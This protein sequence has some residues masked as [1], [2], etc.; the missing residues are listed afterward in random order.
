[1]RFSFSYHKGLLGKAAVAAP[2]CCLVCVPVMAKA[3][4]ITYD[5]GTTLNSDN[6]II[7]NVII[8]P[9]SNIVVNNPVSLNFNSQNIVALQINQNM[10]V[11]GPGASLT[12]TSSGAYGP[13]LLV[14][15][16]TGGSASTLLIDNGAQVSE[17]GYGY[18]QAGW[19]EGTSGTITVTGQG[20][21]LAAYGVVVGNG[22]TTACKKTGCNNTAHGVLNIFN[23]ASVTADQLLVGTYDAQ[24]TINLSNATLTVK[25]NLYTNIGGNG[26][27]NIND[28]GVLV[29]NGQF[30]LGYQS[31]TSHG[32]VNLNQGGVL[33]VNG[34]Q[35]IVDNETAQGGY[36][37]NLAGGTMQII[38]AN[39]TTGVNFNLVNGT[40]S[41]IDTNGY[42][43]T[44][45]GTLSGAG[46]LVK[47]GAGTLIL[48]GSDTY[49][50]GTTIEDGTVQYGTNSNPMNYEGSVSGPL[51]ADLTPDTSLAALQVYGT[52]SLGNALI[53]SLSPPSA[54]LPYVLGAD[55]KVLTATGGVSGGG[56]DQFSSISFSGGY[57]PYL[58]GLPV[59][60]TNDVSVQVLESGNGIDTGRFYAASGYAQNAALFESLSAPEGTGVGYWLHGLGSFGH[61]P[62]VDY[63]YKGFV[64]GRGF[65]VNQALVLGGAISNLYTHTG[66]SNASYAN[67]TT[68][69]G[70]IYGIYTVPRW[71]TTVTTAAGHLH[72]H[73]ERD[74]SGLGSG[75]FSTNGAYAGF[76][77]RTDYDWLTQGATSLTPYAVASYLHTHLGHGQENGLGILDT[78]YGQL[79]TNLAQAGGGVTWSRKVINP[80]NTLTTWVSVGGLGTFGNTHARVDET[81]GLQQASITGEV[82]SPAMFTP[83]AGVQLLGSTAPWKLALA[84]QGQFAKR[85][86]GQAFTLKGSY[87]F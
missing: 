22:D 77:L 59:Y 78:N 71:T 16:V 46:G 82:A 11:S 61:A 65:A 25:S 8:Q 66:G 13:Q 58:I 43:G 23:G 83:A 30:S 34:A 80:G 33:E 86:A 85:A 48:A 19:N 28:G 69:G 51:Y 29:S 2:L 55:Y 4:D 20:S 5:S 32:V 38:N 21:S 40:A 15:T 72:M 14:G 45:T 73:A 56:S 81:I 12:L 64:A 9:G 10:A 31:Y 84:W 36:N 17:A 7:G 54:G 41:T 74:L 42:T 53:L 24:G 67:G 47:A 39:L 79:N 49:T 37:F 52:A 63:N 26:T 44:F 76:S 35:G 70:E 1:M 27:I 75:D 3:Q 68:I 18:V 60:G 57:G 6:N 62:G 87:M 50:G